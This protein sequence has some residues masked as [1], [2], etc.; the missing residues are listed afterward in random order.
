MSYDENKLNGNK[1]LNEAEIKEGLTLLKEGL[2]RGVFSYEHADPIAQ[3][4]YISSGFIEGLYFP[5]TT[6]KLNALKHLNYSIIC[7]AKIGCKISLVYELK[8]DTDQRLK[9]HLKDFISDSLECLVYS[10]DELAIINKLRARIKEHSDTLE[11][12]AKF[13]RV[14][15]KNGED[16]ADLVKNFEGV[17]SISLSRVYG[18]ATAYALTINA[19]YY[20]NRHD[21][22]KA[23][24]PTPTAEEIERLISEY[25]ARER[26]TLEKYKKA[27]KSAPSNY[28]KAQK[29]ANACKEFLNTLTNGEFYIFTEQLKSMIH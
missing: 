26:D 25:K 14:Y 23:K 1:P 22:D 18:E 15:K 17:Y 19:D 13:K 11:N 28:R 27:L 7:I 29:L 6:L 20:M 8:E 5:N 4:C 24:N 10:A 21:E 12:V 9:A 2:K 3:N 16:F